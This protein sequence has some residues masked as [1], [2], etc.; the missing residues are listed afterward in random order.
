[1][2]NTKNIY[3]KVESSILLGDRRTAWFIIE[4]GLRQG[5]IL[6]P[7]LFLLFINDLKEVIDRLGKGVNIGNSRLSILFF[8]DDIAILADSQEDLEY[9]LEVIYKYS[10]Y[11]R[12]CFN[13][14]KC[15][16]VVF[17]Y[18]I[19]PP[20]VYGNCTNDCKCNHHF[21]FG[22][23]L[24][25]EVLLYKYLGVEL[26]YRLVFHEFKDR[27]LARARSNLGRIWNMGI[28]EGV[29]SVKAA[30]NLYQ[31]LVVSGLEYSSEV[32]GFDKWAL[33]E[34][35]QY[36]FAR[37]TLRCSP[38]TS[39]PALVGE[40]GLI[41]LYGRRCYKKLVFWFN[42]INLPDF[43]LVKQVY[44]ESKKQ[45]SKKSNWCN[46]IG[47]IFN[48]YGMMNVWNNNQL[49]FNLD[50]KHNNNAHTLDL[51]KQHWKSYIRKKI[52]QVEE[53]K[54]LELIN[55]RE[56]YSKLRTYCSFKK[57]LHLEPYLVLSSNS[58]G[59]AIHTSLRTGTNKLEIDIG[60]KYGQEEHDRI[61]KYCDLKVIESEKHF[62]IDC[63][64]Y[65]T[66]RSK[67]Y[68]DICNISNRKWNMNNFN[69]DDRFIFLINGSMDDFQKQIFR[70]LHGYLVRCF[71]IR[72]NIH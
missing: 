56:E 64:K 37:Y 70:L 46:R 17:H 21:R 28:R 18:S 55:D 61:C 1:M 50:G 16:V 72:L 31:A 69:D 5:C 27:I 10:T 49:V 60:R 62:L 63:P 38:M 32:W 6:S 3:R 8:A 4:L 20:I 67:L 35:I 14:D 41:S 42:V 13:L 29:L 23:F 34:Q 68:T 39:K 65:D 44:L 58:Y 22:P 40:L 48:E 12:F 54:W 43:R 24:I 25:N 19:R 11:W 30:I 9:M 33:G 15:G 71:K 45:V 2:E 53:K 52:L 36:Q 59:K 66:Y 47:K 7:I 51:H 26:D 57:K